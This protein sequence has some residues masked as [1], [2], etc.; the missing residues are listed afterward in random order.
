MNEWELRLTG[1]GYG[2][3]SPGHHTNS[4]ADEPVLSQKNKK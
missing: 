3:Q 2:S 1:T 4:L